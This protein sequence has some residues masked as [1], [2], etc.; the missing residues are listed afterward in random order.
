MVLVLAMTLSWDRSAEAHGGNVYRNGTQLMLNG[1]PYRFVGVNNYDLTGCHTGTPVAAAAAERFFAQLPPNSMTRV[2]AFEE[3]GFAPVQRTV[4]LAEKYNQKLTLVFADGAGF[5]NAPRFDVAWYTGGFRGS[6]FAWIER[7]TTAFGGSPAVGMWEIMNEPG[8]GVDGLTSDIIKSFYDETA[9]HIKR[10]DPAHLVS[11]GA[12]APWQPFQKGESGYAEV[13]SGPDI[14]VVSVHEFD[15]P[16]TDGE[17][18]VS[19]HFETARRAAQ[20]I[21]KPLY[22]GETGVSLAQGCMTADERADALRRKFTEYLAE[23][24]SGV[25]YWVVLGP[26]NNPGT[27][28]DSP[29]GNRDPMLGGAVMTMITE[30]W[31]Q[32][33]RT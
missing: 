26:P 30:Y 1:A 5:C 29:F 13:H 32:A 31:Q 8:S 12:L 33:G 15:F 9:A 23:G 7:L 24:A 17:A 10:H 22:V 19:T 11:T 3:W 18:I 20:A 6:Y 14:D 16:Y 25:L 2:W 21:G 27:V 28:C 4:R